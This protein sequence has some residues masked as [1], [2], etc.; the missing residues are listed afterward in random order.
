MRGA[1][2]IP[3]RRSVASS[4]RAS[5]ASTDTRAS[6]RTWRRRRC[7]QPCEPRRDVVNVAA[8]AEIVIDGAFAHSPLIPKSPAI[9]GW[10]TGIGERLGYR[11]FLI[12]LLASAGAYGAL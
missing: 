3:R 9:A 8:H 10:M 11:T 7:G 12:A 4:P 1:P 6:T 5:A 2:A